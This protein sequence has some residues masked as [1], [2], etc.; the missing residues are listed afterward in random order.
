MSRI[1]LSIMKGLMFKRHRTRKGGAYRYVTLTQ[2]SVTY[3]ESEKEFAEK[4]YNGRIID[5]K[6]GTVVCGNLLAGQGDPF[7]TVN[8]NAG[9][10]WT[11]E[12]PT[13]ADAK[14]WETA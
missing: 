10:S 2:G 7:F 13:G 6:S 3:F 11:F 8:N 5:L 12:T 9:K 4:P 1:D 14:M